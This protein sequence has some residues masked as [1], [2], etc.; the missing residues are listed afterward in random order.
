MGIS[1]SAPVIPNVEV[2]PLPTVS[3]SSIYVLFH[4]NKIL[5]YESSLEKVT[6]MVADLRQK[7]YMNYVHKMADHH[8]TWEQDITFSSGTEITRHF[9]VSTKKFFI[10]SYDTIETTVGY[11]VVNPC[12][13]EIVDSCLTSEVSEAEA[14][15]EIYEEEIELSEQEEEALSDEEEETINVETKKEN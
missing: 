12:S 2:T 5:G 8:L 10:L 9:L 11:F 3:P 7:I 15:E 14:E 6:E 4:E 13:Q 1:N